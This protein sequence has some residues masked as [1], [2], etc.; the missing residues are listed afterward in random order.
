MLFLA[1]CLGLAVLAMGICLEKNTLTPHHGRLV[2]YQESRYGRIQVHQDQEQR[3]LFLDGNP[4]SSSQ[5]T[6]LAE[7]S[8]HYPLA[9]LDAI[10]NVLLISAEGGVMTELQKYQLPSVDYV[11][12]DPE[13]A[14]VQFRFDMVKK[15]SG[16]NVIHQDGRAFLSQ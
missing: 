5:D 16:L 8:I 14:E 13:V 3:T 6:A 11:E 4:V 2:H 15:I 7:E 9:Q 10:H 1:A 12:L